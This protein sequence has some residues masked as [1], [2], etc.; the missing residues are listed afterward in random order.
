MSEVDECIRLQ[1]N[2]QRVLAL[3]EE[4]GVDFSNAAKGR[5][6]LKEGI[7]VNNIKPRKPSPDVSGVV[8]KK[9]TWSFDALRASGGGGGSRSRTAS[10]STH[11]NDLGAVELQS[12]SPAIT[13]DDRALTLSS[14]LASLVQKRMEFLLF[15][16]FFACGDAATL[17]RAR[18]KRKKREEAG[19]H[20]PPRDA[21]RSFYSR[22][23]EMMHLREETKVRSKFSLA[24]MMVIGGGFVHSA[25]E[26]IALADMPFV[27]PQP[28]MNGADDKEKN[29][30][31]TTKLSAAEVAANNGELQRFLEVRE[32]QERMG[33]RSVWCWEETPQR[34]LSHPPG[35]R[36]SEHMATATAESVV[37]ERGGTWVKYADFVGAQLEFFCAY[38]HFL[39]RVVLIIL[40]PCTGFVLT[41]FRRCNFYVQI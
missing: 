14:A 5:E 21:V 1:A 30:A 13:T 19:E 37:E 17:E 38:F 25:G 40:C 24:D 31:E 8:K 27:S 41:H 7:L 3:S 15:S 29:G 26:S 32:L 20:S 10:N 9:K 16:D 28:S 11:A 4:W 2:R 39:R 12:T 22:V 18:R 35:S 6:L 36:F 33:I 23:K 34:Y